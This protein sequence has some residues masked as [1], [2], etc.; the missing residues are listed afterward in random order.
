MKEQERRLDALVATMAKVR[1][2]LDDMTRARVALRI[3]QSLA[4]APLEVRPPRALLGWLALGSGLAA[5]AL[6]AW[7][8]V[9][10][11]KSPRREDLAAPRLPIAEPKDGVSAWLGAPVQH[12]IDGTSLTFYGPGRLERPPGAVIVDAHAFVIDRDRVEAPQKIIYRGATIWVA[13]ATFAVDGNQGTRV[14]VMRGELLLRCGEDEH[15]VRAGESVTCRPPQRGA[16]QTAELLPAELL[17]AELRQGRG[18]SVANSSWSAPSSSAPTSIRSTTPSPLLPL[19]PVPLAPVSPAI[20]PAVAAPPVIASAV[21]SPSPPPKPPATST[22]QLVVPEDAAS[23]PGLSGS[24]PVT[25]SELE[26]PPTRGPRVNEPSS[27]P[28]PSLTATGSF[29]PAVAYAEAE[30][31]MSIDRASAMVLLRD[32]VARAPLAAESA[33]AML[34]LARLLANRGDLS[35]ATAMIDRLSTHPQAAALAIPSSYL[36]CQIA[37]RSDRGGGRACLT[38]FRASF[39]G[40]VHD[41]DVLARLAAAALADRDCAA[42]RPLIDE[43]LA[44]YP[45]GDSAEVLRASRARCPGDPTGESR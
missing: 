10:I 19:A 40:S 1:P 9:G 21:P 26:T 29:R 39:P 16:I 33:P 6:L 35:E 4:A 13:R 22:E 17:P 11:P 44:R 32:L 27:V 15:P 2:P 30:R 28:S 5:A 12:F 24:T 38:R 8:L 42:A 23:L 37:L 18:A 20:A 25:P 7:L 45:D 34:D 31:L 14:S 41:G 3:H 36:L 43:F